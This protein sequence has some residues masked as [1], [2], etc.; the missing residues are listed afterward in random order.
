MVAVVFKGCGARQKKSL[1]AG[2]GSCSSK[3]VCGLTGVW[4]FSL[5]LRIVEDLGIM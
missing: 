5:E 3:K 2:K 1:G 4:T